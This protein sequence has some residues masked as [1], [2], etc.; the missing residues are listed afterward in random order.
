MNSR[1]CYLI[2]KQKHEFL[3]KFVLIFVPIIPYL[4]NGLPGID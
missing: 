3:K 4:G 2:A 1:W